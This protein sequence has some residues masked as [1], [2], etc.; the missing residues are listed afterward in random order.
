MDIYKPSG[1]DISFFMHLI[2]I[3]FCL[4]GAILL[5]LTSN[6]IKRNKIDERKDYGLDFIAGALLI[7]LI[8]SYLPSFTA[9]D[10]NS[11]GT[12]LSTFNNG[13][14]LASLTFFIYGFETL[15]GRFNI[16]KDSNRWVKVVLLWSVVLSAVLLCFQN[17]NVVGIFDL[18]YSISVLGAIGYAIT[19]SFYK[20]GYGIAFVILGVLFIIINTYSQILNFT[21]ESTPLRAIWANSLIVCSQIFFIMLLL[22]L[23]Q[24]WAVEVEKE[25]IKSLEEVDTEEELNFSEVQAKEEKPK[26]EV[27]FSNMEKRTLQELKKGKTYGEIGSALNR[28]EDTIKFHIKS[29]KKKLGVSGRVNLV[30]LA[31]Q[32]GLKL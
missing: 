13:L 24:S 25:K 30:E 21:N 27:V 8:Q 19:L 29:I 14:L 11:Y 4:F 6:H 28:S 9:L 5:F 10:S 16:F 22:I 12:I 3:A 7:W 18:I 1:E 32:A 23:T 2:Q 17:S 26:K 31:E 15:K 20:R